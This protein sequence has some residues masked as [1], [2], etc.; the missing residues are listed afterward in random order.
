MDG[1]TLPQ[2]VDRNENRGGI[3]LYIR[4]DISYRQIS[5]KNDEDTEHFFC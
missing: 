4:K 1:F 5:F 2:R 3:A